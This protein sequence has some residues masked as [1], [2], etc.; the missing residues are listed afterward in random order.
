MVSPKECFDYFLETGCTTYYTYIC[1]RRITAYI[2][3]QDEFISNIDIDEDQL[4]WYPDD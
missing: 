2:N 4:E 1:G 3:S